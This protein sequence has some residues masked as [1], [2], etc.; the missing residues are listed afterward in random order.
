MGNGTLTTS[1]KYLLGSAI[2]AGA[3]DVQLCCVYAGLG[4]AGLQ[5][6]MLLADTT[7]NRRGL[8]G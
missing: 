1:Q 3:D 4:W 7:L 5:C 6:A 2:G 8:A